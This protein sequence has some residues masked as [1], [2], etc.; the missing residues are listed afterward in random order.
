MNEIITRGAQTP[1]P[2]AVS[3]ASMA[4][5]PLPTSLDV[6]W[7]ACTRRDEL[8]PPPPAEL[9]EARRLLPGLVAAMEPARQADVWDWLRDLQAAHAL[10]EVPATK[11]AVAAACVSLWEVCQEFPRGVW[12]RETRIAYMRE[13]RFWP[14]PAVL[15][16]FLQPF[17]K[18]IRRKHHICKALVGAAEAAKVG[19]ETEAAERAGNS[20]AGAA[21][22]ARA[23]VEMASKALKRVPG[24]NFR[25]GG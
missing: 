8:L 4:L 2:A 3:T 6:H 7:A 11:E 14:L 10:L 19:A 20:G 18:E 5:Q 12:T 24:A 23:V 15:F 21:L 9:A 1:A 13:N 16:S 25:V 22:A 17:A